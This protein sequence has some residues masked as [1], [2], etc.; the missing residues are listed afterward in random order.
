[1]SILNM[2]QDGMPHL[3]LILTR[4]LFHCGPLDKE[5]LLLSCGKGLDIIKDEHIKNTLSNWTLLGLFKVNAN[6]VSI[7]EQHKVALGNNLSSLEILLPSVLTAILL[8]RQNNSDG[9]FWENVKGQ[10]SDFSRALSWMLAQD[11]FAINTTAHTQIDQL[12]NSQILDPNRRLLQN[13]TRWNGLCDWM[14]FL[15]FARNGKSMSIDLTQALKSILPKIFKDTRELNGLRFVERAA[16]LMPVLDGGTYRTK[17]EEILNTTTWSRPNAGYI[18]NSLT[19]ALERLNHE[20]IIQITKSSDAK[21]NGITLTGAKN[22][23]G[24]LITDISY[25]S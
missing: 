6:E 3:V 7:Q 24:R 9:Q 15:G 14:L 20:N 2:T 17:V 23:P 25:I 5:V 11:I 21:K 13:N 22:T 8:S 18:S 16:E 10:S 12:E 4:T 19:R 1:M